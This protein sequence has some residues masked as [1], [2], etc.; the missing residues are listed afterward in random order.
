[1]AIES[2][3]K[4]VAVK[5]Y[6]RGNAIPLD[7]SSTYETYEEA[8]AYAASD[9]TAYEGQMISA[10]VDGKPK[11]YILEANPSGSGFVLGQLGVSAVEWEPIE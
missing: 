4:L 1:M 5:A 3:D 9:P 11:G 7:A 6:A 8:V 10:K 2:K